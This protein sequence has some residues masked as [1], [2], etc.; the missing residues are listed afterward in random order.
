[1]KPM[2]AALLM[3]LIG[4]GPALGQGAG[5]R[6]AGDGADTPGMI[7]HDTARPHAGMQGGGM[8]AAMMAG[9]PCPMMQEG[10]AGGA[11][12]PAGGAKAHARMLRMRGD[13]MKAMGDVM[14]RHADEMDKER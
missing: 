1:M 6:P 14:L 13:M 8:H 2:V 11:M 5:P 4:A 3:V 12:G 10:M 9:G 7:G